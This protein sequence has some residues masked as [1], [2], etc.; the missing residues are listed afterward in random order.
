MRL[1][2][3]QGFIFRVVRYYDQRSAP[4]PKTIKLWHEDVGNIP[5]EALPGMWDLVK[6]W[7]DSYPCR[8][9]F[10]KIMKRAFGQWLK[11][12]PEKRAHR[13]DLEP[14][15]NMPGCSNGVV[16]LWDVDVLK[17]YRCA[18]C[19]RWN[20]RGAQ[21]ITTQQMSERGLVPDS[22]AVSE[23]RAKMARARYQE[24]HGHPTYGRIGGRAAG[25]IG[26]EVRRVKELH[27]WK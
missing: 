27:G 1:D 20:A 5:S 22:M 16:L 4:D 2:E 26:D 8:D 21:S 9:G 17:A 18:S 24:L 3:L 11:D 15:C 25:N 6:E 14:E 13:N 10:P 12:N 19:G 23:A 7:H